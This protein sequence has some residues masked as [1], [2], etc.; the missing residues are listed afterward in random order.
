MDAYGC[1]FMADRGDLFGSGEG[2]SYQRRGP[3]ASAPFVADGNGRRQMNRRA[4][5][6]ILALT[7]PN[8]RTAF[9]DVFRVRTCGRPAS[10]D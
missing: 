4:R 5:V 7:C 1:T 9:S 10:G 3:A 6:R 8:G 2:R